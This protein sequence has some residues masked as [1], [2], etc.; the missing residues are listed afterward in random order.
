MS[1][2]AAGFLLATVAAVATNGAYLVQHAALRTVAPLT[3]RGAAGA[4]RSLL[5]SGAWLRGALLGYAGLGAQIAAMALVPLWLVQ[6]IMAAG[7]V[8]AL[9]GWAWRGQPG[10][11]GR[12]AA[13]V[14]LLGAGLAAVVVGGARTA[15]PASAPLGTLGGF[16]AVVTTAA[17]LLPHGADR[18]RRSSRDAL[19]GGLLYG[20]TTTAIAAALASAGHDLVLAAALLG[21]AGATAIVGLVRFQ[22]ALQAGDPVTGVLLMSAAM[23]TV[24]LLGGLLLVGGGA[25]GPVG[26]AGVVALCGAGFMAAAGGTPRET[27]MWQPSR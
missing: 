18:L 10:D 5:Q 27:A 14:M 6:A 24:A 22:R 3:S 19:S 20:V 7:L 2:T 12:L 4:L 11:P 16:A 15:P 8:V 13:A 21:L 26:L 23:N 9:G 1:P 25:P 17:V